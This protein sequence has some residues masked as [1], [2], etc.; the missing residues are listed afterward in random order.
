MSSAEDRLDRELARIGRQVPAT[1]GFLRWIREPHMH[2]VRIPLALLLIL[3]GVFS[4]LPILGIWML[5]LGLAVL[6]IDVPPLKA[7]V[8]NTL[9]R[10]QRRLVVT[11]RRLRRHNRTT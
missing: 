9:V 6:A 4:F 2:M 8:A 7:P 10:L 1:A 5:P 3:G 11:R